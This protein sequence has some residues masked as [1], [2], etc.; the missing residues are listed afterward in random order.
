MPGEQV[1]FERGED[2]VEALVL[3]DPGVLDAIRE[4]APAEAAGRFRGFRTR[5]D[6]RRVAALVAAV[7]AFGT[8][9]YLWG[10][11]LLADRL[12]AK[13]PVSWEE[14][15]GRSARDQM[16]AVAGRCTDSLLLSTVERLVG[17]LAVA[18]SSPY[19]FRTVVSA[20]D[21][22]NAFAA[23]GGYIVLNRGLIRRTARPEELAGVLAH[24]M[25]HVLR[26]H[27]TRAILRQVPTRLVLAAL[28]GDAAGAS[29][30]AQALGT[31]GNLRY[32]RGDEEEAD[33]LGI[34]LLND[35]GAD[36]T[37]MADFFATLERQAGDVPR[38]LGYLSTHP[39]TAERIERTR[40]LA[41][42]AGGARPLL[43]E[44]RWEVVRERCD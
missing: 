13:V 32:Q 30:A 44:V 6:W 18:T 16:L 28:A 7:V 27:G 38:G 11:P 15:L 26:R 36:A 42:Q 37:G 33:V 23:P 17:Q 5:L 25:Q 34:A 21:Q 14:E 39:R 41:A 31:L 35:A 19:T 20:G 22:V 29:Q 24:E 40:Q 12:A 8:G 4:L 9:L 10:I 1:R 43:P 2:P 3:H